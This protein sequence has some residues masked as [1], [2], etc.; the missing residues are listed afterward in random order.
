M[1]DYSTLNPVKNRRTN[2]TLLFKLGFTAMLTLMHSNSIKLVQYVLGFNFNIINIVISSSLFAHRCHVLNAIPF[3]VCFC[4]SPVGS[5][6][7]VSNEYDIKIYNTG[8]PILV[9]QCTSQEGEPWISFL[10]GYQQQGKQPP[11][12]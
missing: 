11:P 7:D 5:G 9:H 12:L 1:H 8:G 4:F 10:F 2:W 6:V 3:S